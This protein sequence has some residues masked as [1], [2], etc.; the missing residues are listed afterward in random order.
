MSEYAIAAEKLCFSYS[1]APLFTDLDF[2]VKSG[3]FLALVGPNG[4]GKSTF[5]KLVL[6][7]LR[8]QSGLVRIFGK[9][10][11]EV[12]RS[13]G[14]VPQYSTLRDDFPASLLEAVLMG[15][16]RSS[17][18]GGFWPRDRQATRKAMELLEK[19]KL[20]QLA[21]KDISELSGGERQRALIARALM[22]RENEDTPFLLLLDEPT[23]SIDPAGKFCFYEFLADLK[24][25][26]TIV[27]VSH[28]MLL[29]SPFFTRVVY[30]NR[31]L[32]DL[33][34]KNLTPET[35]TILFGE[36]AH[37]CPVSDLNHVA[38]V[39]SDCCPGA[40]LR[41]ISASAS[42]RTPHGQENAEHP[43]SPATL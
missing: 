30:L 19:M 12:C 42:C 14:Y 9:Q 7:I 8:P 36:H 22:G 4:G 27:I 25:N 21:G 37:P 10:P 31:T 20:P 3:D 16:A 5:L 29:T 39:H 40:Q 13:V 18:L 1:S 6:G 34:H 11:N 35:L 17:P 28:E 33:P 23:A 2:S 32:Q 43:G 24:N 38:Q 15:A 41:E 26:I